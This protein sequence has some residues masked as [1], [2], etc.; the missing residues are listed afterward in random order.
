MGRVGATAFILACIPAGSLG[1]PPG[2]LP[3]ELTLGLTGGRAV[4]GPPVLAACTAANG[5]AVPEE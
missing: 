3:V 4:A 2:I 1:I 5:L